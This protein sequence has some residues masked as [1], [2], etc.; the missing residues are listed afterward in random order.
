MFKILLLVFEIAGDVLELN[1][2]DP[3]TQGRCNHCGAA[4]DKEYIF[5]A[6]QQ[7]LSY[8]IDAAGCR[9][10]E[11]SNSNSQEILTER[12]QPQAEK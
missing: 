12:G 2:R 10:Q 11:Y 9:C 1:K 5:E 3:G 8:C 6:G 4:Y 7:Q